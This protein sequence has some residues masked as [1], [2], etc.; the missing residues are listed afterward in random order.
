L[1]S[2]GNNKPTKLLSIQAL[3]KKKIIGEGREGGSGGLCFHYKDKVG[4]ILAR[5]WRS[6]QEYKQIMADFGLSFE[7]SHLSFTSPYI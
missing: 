7:I 3:Q 1:V 4:L 6:S 5:T 2:K